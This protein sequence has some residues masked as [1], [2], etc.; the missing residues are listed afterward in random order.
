MWFN[1]ALAM[2]AWISSAQADTTHG[3]HQEHQRQYDA[4]GVQPVQSTRSHQKVRST[5]AAKPSVTVYG[6]HPYWEDDPTELDF[7]RL[8]HLAIFDVGL[9]EDGSLSSTSR[10]TS[11][12]PDVVPLAHAAGVKVHLCVTSFDDDVMAAVLPSPT[13]RAA[14]IDAMVTL[15]DD[16][17]ADGV[18]I[19]FEGMDS[20]LKDDLVTFIEE[21][22]LETDEVVLAT[23]AIDWSGAYDYDR[24]AEASDGLFIMGYG[25]YWSGGNPGP[26]APLFAGDPWHSYSLEWSV[27]DYLTYDATRDKIILGLPLYGHEWPTES[28]DIPGTATGSASAV[29]MSAAVSIGEDEGALWDEASHTKYVLWSDAQLWYD[30]TETLRPKI[31]WA[32]ENNLQGIG[33]WALGY[34]GNDT[35]FWDMVTEETAFVSADTGAPS[36]DTGSESGDTDIPSDD[37]GTSD[38]SLETHAE[39]FDDTDAKKGCG[40]TTGRSHSLALTRNLGWSAMWLLPLFGLLAWRRRN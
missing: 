27:N 10:W 38:T 11:T 19:D 13:L 4:T 33:F 17:G 20:A 21:L 25:Y 15:V 14:A 9:E 36:D 7:S 8:T 5:A 16:V 31:A 40:C 3:A 34:E 28:D 29:S 12:A 6:Y 22:K 26:N 30:D 39:S 1:T 18:N 35:N 24:L 23:P 37:S 2:G 32:V